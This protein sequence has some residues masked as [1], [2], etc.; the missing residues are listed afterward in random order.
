M[1]SRLASNSYEAND[2]LLLI[3]LPSAPSDAITS[4]D[5]LIWSIWTWAWGTQCSPDKRSSDRA[6]P[7]SN[8]LARFF[9]APALCSCWQTSLSTA[10]FS[11]TYRGICLIS[12]LLPLLP[13]FPTSLTPTSPV[14]QHT[15]T[16]FHA[17]QDT[18]RQR[19]PAHCPVL[20]PT[21][22]N[23]F[24]CPDRSYKLGPVV[25]STKL[26]NIFK[27]RLPI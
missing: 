11:F 13:A 23:G 15:H 17:C 2:L 20:C 5:Y 16:H 3:L 19:W 14:Q 9:S 24:T 26:G 1:Q 12:G 27:S 21:I 25:T 6:H 18:Q 7:Q 4:M 10:G 22:S 8:P